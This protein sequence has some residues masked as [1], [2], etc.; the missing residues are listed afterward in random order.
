[1][2]I[3]ER[4][5][6]AIIFANMHD[7]SIPNLTKDR[8]FA[9][10]PFGG[11]YRMIDFPLSNCINA[12]IVD[13]GIV[14]KAN[15][16]SLMEHI[17]NGSEWDLDRKRGGLKILPPYGNKNFGI[18]HGKLE[19]LG[20][21]LE[22]IKR[23]PCKYILLS[24]CDLVANM[25]YAEL[26]NEHIKTGSD[27]SV[28]Y[29]NDFLDREMAGNS[30]I[31]NFDDDK[32]L[33]EVMINPNIEGCMNFSL[34]IFIFERD[35]LHTLITSSICKGDYKLDRDF[36]QKKC[37]E[38]KIRGIEYKGYVHPI[39]SLQSYYKANMDLLKHEVRE[40]LFNFDR[41][42]YTRV[43]D[44]A[45]V[46]YGANS[47]VTDSFIADGC[48][49]DGYVEHSII[50]RGCK[51]SSGTCVKNSI[52]MQKTRVGENCDLQ[53]VISDKNVRIKDGRTLIS[54]E[55]YPTYISKNTNI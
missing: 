38:Y 11:R 15:Y 4:M 54:N 30:V 49:I 33:K 27:V 55:Q 20:A 23:I 14:T 45:P 42:I 8:T 5:V 53:Y 52:L 35:F 16:Q 32:I 21:A 47:R 46:K 37:K 39:C 25:D 10:V 17:D 12:G 19:A 34:N 26:I 7:S 51:V 13:I 40:K 24:D 6:G 3:N 1:M 2:L 22:F 9:S 18:Y 41:P 43:S 28:V 29:K 48:I 31:F 36:L 50:F 44:E